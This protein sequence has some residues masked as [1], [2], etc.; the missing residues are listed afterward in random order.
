MSPPPGPFSSAAKAPSLAAEA[1]HIRHAA[2]AEGPAGHAPHGFGV[3]A[4]MPDKAAADPCQRPLLAVAAIDH[5]VLQMPRP[6]LQQRKAAGAAG[7]D[8]PVVAGVHADLAE[9]IAVDV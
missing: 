4:I 6:L 8:V 5:G 3:H 7:G 1:E 9:I 2:R